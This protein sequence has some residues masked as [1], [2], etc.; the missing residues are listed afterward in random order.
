MDFFGMPNHDDLS[1]VDPVCE[2]LI[3]F[4]YLK[5]DSRFDVSVCPRLPPWK[6]F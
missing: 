4:R 1:C 5:A 3:D 6:A 2:P